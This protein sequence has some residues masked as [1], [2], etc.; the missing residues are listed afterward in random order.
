MYLDCYRASII[1]L[2]IRG[3]F[4]LHGFFRKMNFKVFI[5]LLVVSCCV[6]APISEAE[7]SLNTVTMDDDIRREPWLTYQKI[8]TLE[9][10]FVTMNC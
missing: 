7:S 2:A 3:F 10:T 6:V 4:L 1:I 9:K 8:L 5:V